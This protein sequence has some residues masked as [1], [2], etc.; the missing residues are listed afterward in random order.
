MINE[1]NK[2]SD[3]APNAELGTSLSKPMNIALV[4]GVGNASVELCKINV[5]D[6]QCVSAATYS[7]IDDE[8]FYIN[9]K[10]II[11]QTIANSSDQLI[12]Y[13]KSSNFALVPTPLFLKDKAY[14]YLK[15][16]CPISDEE[17]ILCND[18]PEFD[19]SVVFKLDRYIDKELCKL[20]GK[21]N[22]IH[23]AS[24]CLYYIGKILADTMTKGQTHLYISLYQEDMYLTILQ[25]ERLIYH[26]IF[27]IYEDVNLFL[28]YVRTTLYCLGI[29]DKLGVTL[30]GNIDGNSPYYIALKA[31]IKKVFI[32]NIADQ[33]RY[34]YIK[35]E[36]KYKSYTELCKAYMNAERL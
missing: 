2:N 28:K 13:V 22:I 21:V 19:A 10:Y 24:S 16:M 32:H 33:E 4:L 26:N 17:T 15:F 18:E 6:K 14:H 35:L 11:Q 8:A 27:S 29:S 3:Y 7:Y 31:H 25:G 12:L 36:D 34:N 1:E 20:G 23:Q 9:H 30:I 5:R